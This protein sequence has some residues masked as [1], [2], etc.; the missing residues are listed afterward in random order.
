MLWYITCLLAYDL[1]SSSFWDLL[2]SDS[3]CWTHERSG[4]VSTAPAR[5]SLVPTVLRCRRA[6]GFTLFDEVCVS[7]FGTWAAVWRPGCGIVLRA[8]PCCGGVCSDTIVRHVRSSC[9][10]V[11]QR[12]SYLGTVTTCRGCPKFLCRVGGCR[13]ADLVVFIDVVDWRWCFWCSSCTGLD[14]G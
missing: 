3:N 1:T 11:S 9:T 10:G 14:P 4:S 2:S 5:P 7:R 6:C 12:S 8:P 13:Q